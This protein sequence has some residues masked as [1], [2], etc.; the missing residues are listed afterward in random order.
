VKIKVRPEDFQVEELLRLRFARRGRY[1]ICRLEKRDW[2]TLEV[3]RHIE[4]KY[5]LGRLSRA[6]LKDRHSCSVQYVSAEG[7]AP[8]RIDEGTF[9]LKHIGY[10]TKPVTRELLL[11]NRFRIVIR[12]LTGREIA[13]A[14][15]NLPEAQTDGFPNYHDEQRFGS[16][17]SGQGFIGRRLI[18]GDLSAALRLYLATPSANDD[19]DS[20]RHTEFI[21]QH[22]GD[23][24][25]CL[26]HAK[27]EFAPVLYHLK[28]APDDLAG[29]VSSIQHDLLELFVTGYQSYLWNE[30]LAELIRNFGL[31]AQAVPYAQGELLF[32]TGLSDAARQFFARHEIP[33]ASPM[34]ILSPPPVA[35]AV[36]AV[37]V[38]EGIGLKDLKLPL[39]IKGI[40]F[41]PYARPGVVV[42]KE[43]RLSRPEPDELHR[44]KQKLELTFDL[45]PGSYA[46]I[47]VRRLLLPTS[48]PPAATSR[49]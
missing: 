3:L 26:R 1:S 48:A 29:A 43:L 49:S 36:T 4:R 45:P 5:R 21:A 41:K 30:T 27:P 7:H 2:G 32:F 14:Q 22:W 17:R 39:R 16:A 34:T 25:P 37:L 20:R 24:T 42:P 15:R 12:D 47:L 23:W 6:G 33:M 31:V 10:S 46:T 9:I 11:G 28:K 40:G 18:E 8:R 38:R 19:A 35:R 13:T 44:G